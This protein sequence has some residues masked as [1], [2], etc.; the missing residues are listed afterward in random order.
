MERLYGEYEY[1]FEDVERSKGME[2]V[3]KY[4][5]MK[6]VIV[7]NLSHDVLQFNFYDHSKLILSSHGL[8]VTHIDKNYNITRWTLAEVMS[9]AIKPPSDLTA[10][11]LKFQQRLFDKLKYCKE[12]LVSIKSASQNQGGDGQQQGELEEPAAVG[13]VKGGLNSAAQGGRMR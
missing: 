3:Q 2:W 11:Q 10:D 8:L 4:L 7:F 1:A 5:R 6:H 9:N 12:I 13:S